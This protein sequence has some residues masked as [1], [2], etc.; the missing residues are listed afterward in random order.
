M[1]GPDELTDSSARAAFGRLEKHLTTR[2]GLPNRKEGGTSPRVFWELPKTTVR[3]VNLNV[4]GISRTNFLYA[5]S[6]GPADTR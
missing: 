5:P 4:F 2:Y 3:L 6:T 1:V